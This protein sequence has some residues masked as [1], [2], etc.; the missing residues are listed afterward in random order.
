[1]TEPSL[2]V[3]AAEGKLDST[4]GPPAQTALQEPWG[5]GITA[6]H[7]YATCNPSSQQWFATKLGLSAPVM[8]S[9][10]HAATHNFS[11]F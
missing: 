9:L 5:K 11:V 8:I 10:R 6:E 2:L 1:M 7:C 4:A 3:L